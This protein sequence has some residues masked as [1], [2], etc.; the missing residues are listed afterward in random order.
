M[1]AY[2]AVVKHEIDASPGQRVAA[3]TQGLEEIAMEL[4]GEL[5]KDAAFIERALEEAQSAAEHELEMRRHREEDQ[6]GGEGRG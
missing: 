1:T 6:E 2:R 5:G 4:A 3:L